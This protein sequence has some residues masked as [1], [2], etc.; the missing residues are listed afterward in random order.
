MDRQYTTLDEAR[1]IIDPLINAIEDEEIRRCA[2]VHLYGV[3]LMASTLA[4]KRGHDRRTAELAEIAGMLHDLLCYVDTEEDT[5]DHAHK[6]AEYA[7]ETV[8]SRMTGLSQEE[9]D[10]ICQAVYNHSD[11]H[12]RG[13]WFDEILKDADVLQHGLRNPME[14]YFYLRPRT[15]QVLQEL[16]SGQKG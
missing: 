5:D 1:S 15:Q 16:I 2:Y 3:G 10:M 14:D 12:V 9:R 13:H 4:F 6:C 8:L 11:K 7:R